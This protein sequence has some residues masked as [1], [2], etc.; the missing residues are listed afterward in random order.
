MILGSKHVGAI[1]SVLTWNFI[2]CI[3]WLLIKVI[4]RNARCNNMDYLLVFVKVDRLELRKSYQVGAYKN[5]QL[6]PFAFPPFL[7]TWV[8]LVL[9]AHP[10]LVHLREVHQD[11]VDGISNLSIPQ[12]NSKKKKKKISTLYKSDT[13][14]HKTQH[15]TQSSVNTRT[16]LHFAINC[17]T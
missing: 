17:A 4:L 1:L 10:Q 15:T 16:F 9:H 5:T 8:S 12:N 6:L 14:T 3:C 2:Q 7:I 13:Y 11:K